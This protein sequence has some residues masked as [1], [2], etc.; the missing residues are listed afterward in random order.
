MA[1]ENHTAF[2]S[3]LLAF[4]RLEGAACSSGWMLEASPQRS[5]SRHQQPMDISMTAN[6]PY[7]AFVDGFVP[8]AE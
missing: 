5:V 6:N 3:R 8:F 2:Y 7:R 4:H 1:A